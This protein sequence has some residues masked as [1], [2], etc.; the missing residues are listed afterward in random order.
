ISGQPI[1][2]I[3]ADIDFFKNVNDNYGHIYGDKVLKD[4]SSLITK[5]IRKNN[6][7]VGRYGGEEFFVV[8]NNTDINGAYRVAEKIRMEL[9]RTKFVYGDISINITASLGVIEARDVNMTLEEVIRG[10]DRNLYKA[11]QSGRNRTC[12]DTEFA[13]L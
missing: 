11:K 7:W 13:G 8:L 9:E 4:F 6:D 1:S 10:V 12:R 2:V 3:M 5:N